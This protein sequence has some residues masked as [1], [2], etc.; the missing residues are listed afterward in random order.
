VEQRPSGDMLLLSL[1][2]HGIWAS[3]DPLGFSFPYVNYRVG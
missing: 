2:K 1:T 3:R